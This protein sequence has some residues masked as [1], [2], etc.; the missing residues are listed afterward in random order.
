MLKTRILSACVFVPVIL[1][2]VF[3]GSWVFTALVLAIVVIGGY[4]YGKMVEVNDCHFLPW[5]YYPSAVILVA[6]A[7]LFPENPGI[8]LAALF[9]SFAAYMIFFILSKYPLNAIAVNFAA[10]V[11]L[12]MT[13]C[14]AILL[15]SSIEDGMWFLYLLLII[16]WFTDSGAYLLGS[17]FGRHKLMP[18]VSPKK[19]VEGAV[20]GIVVAVIGALLLNAFTGLLPVGL[21]IV[22][23]VVVSIGGQI[24][25]L[26]ES[27][28]KRWAG[29]KDSGKLIPGH[30]GVLDRFDSMLFASPLLYFIV[31]VYLMF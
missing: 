10:V 16:Q 4:E 14:T 3:F 31:S 19:S 29:V 8:L 21:M 25:D 17:A 9:L 27:A 26:C 22:A 20:G 18:K 30:G 28:V 6:L 13:M 15:R 12:P 23:A 1:A 11:Y 5:L 2:A 7:Q 24:G